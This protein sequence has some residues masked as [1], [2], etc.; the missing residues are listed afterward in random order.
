MTFE[1]YLAWI[2][3]L[4][5]SSSSIDCH[6]IF[7]GYVE[8]RQRVIIANVL[9]CLPFMCLSPYAV[10]GWTRKCKLF[11]TKK[12]D[13]KKKRKKKKSETFHHSPYQPTAHNIHQHAIHP[14]INPVPLS[15]MHR[16]CTVWIAILQNTAYIKA[17]TG[18]KKTAR[19]HTFSPSSDYTFN[20]LA[21]LK[22]IKA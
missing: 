4:T 1:K 5:H 6:L 17:C 21:N 3:E 14:Q 19:W 11:N 13:K 20:P 12:K 8:R 15:S 7:R 18:G 2:P 22:L 10:P 16:H 9:P